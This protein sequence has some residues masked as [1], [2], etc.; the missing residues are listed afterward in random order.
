MICVCFNSAIQIEWLYD[1][2]F[3]SCGDATVFE[4]L[5]VYDV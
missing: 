5:C 2:V 3:E 1:I 4:E